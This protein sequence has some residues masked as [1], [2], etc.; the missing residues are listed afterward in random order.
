[1]CEDAGCRAVDATLEMDD[2]D[3]PPGWD[4]VIRN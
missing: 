1:V 2:E 4:T 3:G